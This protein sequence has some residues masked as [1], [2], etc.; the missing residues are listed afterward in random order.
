MVP[1]TLGRCKEETRDPWGKPVARLV[2]SRLNSET[3][4]V[5][6]VAN[7]QGQPC[8]CEPSRVITKG[9]YMHTYPHIHVHPHVRTWIHTFMQHLIYP[10]EEKVT[11][12]TLRID[13]TDLVNIYS[14]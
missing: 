13:D 1:C 2:S 11:K 6:K 9:I 3:G 10:K 4:S 14:K 12:E 8:H 7:S 5:H